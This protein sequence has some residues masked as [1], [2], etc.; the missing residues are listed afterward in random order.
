MSSRC[1]RTNYRG[2][3][4]PA[5]LVADTA[6]SC[7]T[8]GLGACQ[9][10]TA[11]LCTPSPGSAGSQPGSSLGTACG[12]LTCCRAAAPHPRG[13]PAYCSGFRGTGAGRSHPSLGGQSLSHP[14]LLG[15]QIGKS[16]ACSVVPEWLLPFYRGNHTEKLHPTL[17]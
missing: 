3:Q 11:E 1:I 5:E 4:H 8:Y 9:G 10:P 6:A 13:P 14:G 15:G 7:T 17:P 2:V 16:Q 12:L